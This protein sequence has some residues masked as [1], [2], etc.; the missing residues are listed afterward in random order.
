MIKI[1]SAKGIINHFNKSI[2]IKQEFLN[3]QTNLDSFYEAVRICVECLKEGG[4]IYLAGNGGSA[5][6]AQHFAAELVCKFSRDRN[7]IPAESLTTDSSIITAISND[8]SYDSIFERQL[9]AKLKCEDI[10]IGIT[11]SGN[12]KNIIKALG[13]V[14]IKKAKSILFAGNGG[15]KIVNLSNIA[16]LVPSS[17]TKFIQETHIMLLHVLCETIE[18]NLIFQTKN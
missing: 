11:T 6:D 9:K 14:K 15:K 17:E 18:N 13:E 4:R 7:P 10:F 16:I 1:N 2:Q 8:Y 12:S 3:N 5:A